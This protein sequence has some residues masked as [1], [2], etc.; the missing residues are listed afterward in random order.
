MPLNKKA[1]ADCN[2][3]VRDIK[4]WLA[5]FALDAEAK[6]VLGKKLDEIANLIGH[7]A[8]DVD[9]RNGENWV[10][11]AKNWLAVF[12]TEYAVSQEAVDTLQEKLDGLAEKLGHVGAK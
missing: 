2:N 6:D 9:V 11:D 8:S 12:K 10:R 3:C 4:N 5:V 7:A 1:L